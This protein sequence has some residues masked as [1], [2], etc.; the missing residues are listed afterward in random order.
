MARAVTGIDIARSDTI[1]TPRSSIYNSYDS[2]SGSYY[3][4]SSHIPG[5]TSTDDSSYKVY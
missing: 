1:S 2:V 5:Y 3:H 4:S